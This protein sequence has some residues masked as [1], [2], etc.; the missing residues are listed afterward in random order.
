M[1]RTGAFLLAPSRQRLGVPLTILPHTG[2]ALAQK[3]PTQNACSAQARQLCPRRLPP[4]WPFRPRSLSVCT[5][6]QAGALPSCTAPWH[7]GWV[8]LRTEV[9]REASKGKCR[10]C[11]GRMM[12]DTVGWAWEPRSP[13]QRQ[14]Q[15]TEV[16]RHAESLRLAGA[17][18]RLSH[19]HL[20]WWE[21]PA[22]GGRGPGRM[23][24]PSQPLRAVPPFRKAHRAAGKEH[25]SGKHTLP[26]PPAPASLTSSS[27]LRSPEPIL[28]RCG[29]SDK[30]RHERKSPL[31]GLR[32]KAP[33]HLWP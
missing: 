27:F 26:G 4:A 19:L 1:V 12:S 3:Y 17:C 32:N 2:R 5:P 28:W 21:S 13:A 10:I 30:P 33:Q 6:P 24:R 23:A 20:L 9:T 18:Q 15:D 14:D 31:G 16:S 11:L 22:G 25:T 29:L 8:S 7:S